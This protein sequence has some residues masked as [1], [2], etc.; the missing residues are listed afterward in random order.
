MNPRRRVALMLFSLLGFL[1]AAAGVNRIVD[2][3]DAWPPNL[4]ADGYR[5]GAAIGDDPRSAG[6]ERVTTAFRLERARPRVLLLGTSNV[7]IGMYVASRERGDFFNAAQVGATLDELSTLLQVAIDHHPPE[8]IVWGVD[9]FAFHENLT[10]FRF[11]DGGVRLQTYRAPSL[12]WLLQRWR[13]TLLSLNALD[14][15]GRLLWRAVRGRRRFD[16]EVPWSP[17]RIHAELDRFRDVRLPEVSF[18]AWRETFWLELYR[19]IEPLPGRMRFLAEAAARAESAGSR[20]IF[21]IPP[22]TRLQLRVFDGDREWAK[23]QA[24]K[25][26]LVATVGA[27]WDLSGYSDF[28]RTEGFFADFLHMRP[29]TG[30]VVLRRLLGQRC[31]GCGELARVVEGAIAYVTPD[32][33]ERHLARQDEERRRHCETC[34]GATLSGSE[35]G[36][37]S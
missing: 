16:P 34:N 32:N 24:W 35:T 1:L 14:Q 36:E 23:F 21:L 9:F 19:T 8:T 29:V 30:Q 20:V 27:Y 6:V 10:G 18:R 7:L 25:R 2:P 31:E 13:Y 4:F 5:A 33:I 26:Q 3:Y 37:R 12:T 22:M 11:G 17:E 28:S 15:S